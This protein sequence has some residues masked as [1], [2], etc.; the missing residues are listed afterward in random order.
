MR[1]KGRHLLLFLHQSS[2]ILRD[3]RRE[4]SL[5]PHPFRSR[6]R[7]GTWS[8]GILLLQWGL[9]GERSRRI[10]SSFPLLT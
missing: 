5:P 4:T 9:V 3:R 2:R 8:W 6:G 7:G 10:R 1:R